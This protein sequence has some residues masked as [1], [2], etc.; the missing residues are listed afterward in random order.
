MSGERST[1][2]I[3]DYHFSTLHD[4]DPTRPELLRR[5]RRM[6]PGNRPRAFKA[7]PEA[8]RRGLP[9]G[10]L[11]SSPTA[12]EVL[13]GARGQ[14]RP[15]DEALLAT[16]L[17]LGGGVVR[18]AT[19]LDGNK[20]W[21]RAA[22]SAGNL[23]PVDLYVVGGAAG[24]VSYY[25]PLA[26]ELVEVRAAAGASGA[27]DRAT[28]VLS[29]VA[30]RTC[31]KYGERGW[32]HVFWDAGTMLANLLAA[33]DAYGVDVSVSTAFDDHE[34]SALLGL[35][36][37]WEFPVA[38]VHLG[39]GVDPLPGSLDLRPPAPSLLVAPSPVAFPLIDAA[40]EASRLD[41]AEVRSWLEAAH[42]ASPRWATGREELS[43][44]RT[45][46]DEPLE[47][48]ILRRGSTR[49]FRAE[50]AAGELLSWVLAA[51]TR[52]AP[53]DADAAVCLRHALNVHDV[54]GVGVGAYTLGADG[55]LA[56][57]AAR[58]LGRAGYEPDALRAVSEHLCLNQPRGG[59][60]AWTIFHCTDLPWLLDTLGPRGYRLAN[61]EA[62]LVSGRIALAATALGG[63]ATALTFYDQAVSETFGLPVAPLLATAVGPAA[64]R[65]RRG[66]TPG[67]PVELVFG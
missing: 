63:G 57:Q 54:A 28:V 29:G 20:V 34:V 19:D 64:S 16:L 58:D 62:G 36:P 31:W 30:F 37:E 18:Q 13:S 60:A 45:T 46:S 59:A 53:I 2:A 27:S 8:P 15:L 66:G 35:D 38:L 40:L 12:T 5:F 7:Y 1:E 10:L 61:L 17:F 41:A 11:A 21:F 50:T 6:D 22:M 3:E 67:H 43:P 4:A 33:A 25:D 32:R 39:P 52:R 48:V 26:H 49:R 44:P 42:D 47:Q 9:P 56:P 55:E 24:G 51:A 65:P 14:A 23:H